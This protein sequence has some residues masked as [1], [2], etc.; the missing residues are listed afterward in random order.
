MAGTF[1]RD[2]W[3][4]AS[5]ASGRGVGEL[6]SGDAHGASLGCEAPNADTDCHADHAAHAN[7]TPGCTTSF[8]LASH[9]GTTGQ[10]LDQFLGIAAV[11][12]SDVWVVG[13]DE[14]SNTPQTLIQ[15][16]DGASWSLVP[17]P[18]SATGGYLAAVA[19]LSST[20][21][22]AVGSTDDPTPGRR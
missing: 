9:P 14:P 7:P 5:R 12:A 22:W 18:N 13:E 4:A 8:T 10:Y 21:V 16:W 6:G 11:S 3:G 17:S 1:R 2:G 15:H 19:A 20:N